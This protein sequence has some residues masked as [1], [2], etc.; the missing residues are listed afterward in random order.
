MLNES[1]NRIAAWIFPFWMLVLFLS[2]ALSVFLLGHLYVTSPHYPFN[3]DDLMCI[4]LCDDLVH[5]RNLIGWHFPCAPYVFPDLPLLAPCHLLAPNI[6]VEFLAYSFVFHACLVAVLA[7][8]GRSSGLTW[9]RSLPAAACGT[10]LLAATHL[11]TDSFD[12]AVLLVHPASHCGAIL[13]GLF[14]LALSARS[15]RYGQSWIGAVVFVLVGG[16]GAFSDKLVVVQLMV[17]LALALIVLTAFRLLPVKQ[18]ALQGVSIGAAILLAIGIKSFLQ[19]LGFQFMEINQLGVKLLDSKP[20]FLHLGLSKAVPLLRQLYHSVER[21]HVLC[22][23]VPLHLLAALCLLKVNSRKPSDT[24]ADGPVNR[25]VVLLAALTLVLSPPCILG[26][27]LAGGMAQHYGTYRYTLSCWFLPCLFLPLL[28]CWL[29]GRRVRVASTLVQL[30]VVLYAVQRASVLVPQMERS[31]FAPPYPP[32]AQA[33]DKLARERG[34]LRGLGGY[35]LARS[36]SWFTRENVVISPLL[37]MGIPWFHA[38]NPDRFLSANSE[39]LRVPDYQFLLLRAG[40]HMCPS[41]NIA[42][43]AFG[44]PREKIVIGSDEIWLYDSLRSSAFDRFLRSRLAERLHSRRP[45]VGPVA[46][47]CLARPKANMTPANARGTVAL[48]PKHPLEIRFAEPVS[49]RLIDV[50]AHYSNQLDLVF[51]RGEQRLG[52]L[53]VP[54]VPLTGAAFELPGIQ[55]RLLP[56]PA[57]LREKKWDRVIVNPVAESGYLSLGHFLVFAE[58]LPEP[59]SPPRAFP[60]R[61]RLTADDLFPRLRENGDPS[62]ARLGDSCPI[63]FSPEMTLSPGRYRVEYSIQVEDNA[64]ALEVASLTV[65]SH[66]PQKLL[67]MRILRANEFRAPGEYVT[68]TLTFETAEETDF[69]LCGLAST[70]RTRVVLDHI[71]LIAESVDRPEKKD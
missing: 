24:S 19:S 67:A 16:L 56:V 34:P 37:Q 7:W 27:L 58:G 32:L 17:P 15:L 10:I 68:Q 5:G 46:P 13:V 35:W 60:P 53:H 1:R 4:D 26:A 47:V 66:T 42:T 20:P 6:V 48:D 43:L 40:D 61:V 25:R 50:G 51:Y 57:S 69:V 33:L 28:I 9:R 64:S 31:E 63:V 71:D 30:S 14:L 45:Y 12:R 70:G 41:A 21:Q 2:A 8:L 55:S 62:M 29:P 65:L 23:L 49:G 38:S 54:A 59:P 11:N 18:A 3:T 39:D 22:V 44:E 36:F 52:E